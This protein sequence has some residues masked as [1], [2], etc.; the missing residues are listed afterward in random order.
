MRRKSRNLLSAAGSVYVGMAWVGCLPIPG[1]ANIRIFEICGVAVREN[2]VAPSIVTT[3]KP[4]GRVVRTA[5][6]RR[7]IAIIRNLAGVCSFLGIAWPHCLRLL[8]QAIR[9]AFVFAMVRAGSNKAA[10]MAMMAITTSSSTRVN[11]LRSASRGW[12]RRLHS[13]VLAIIMWTRNRA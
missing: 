9:S 5:E 11:P 13:M 1:H 6:I 12:P 3:G 2:D 10:R 7:V 8:R 4:G